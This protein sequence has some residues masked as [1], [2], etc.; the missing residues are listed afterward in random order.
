MSQRGLT[1]NNGAQLGSPPGPPIARGDVVS[2]MLRREPMVSQPMVAKLLGCEL[3]MRL[4]HMYIADTLRS[5]NRKDGLPTT[6]RS[7][8]QQK[9]L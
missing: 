3:A 9:G 1:L 4:R 8:I 7:E 2:D 6:Y 5:D